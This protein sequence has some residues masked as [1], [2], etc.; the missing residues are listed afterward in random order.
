MTSR[1]CRRLR[2]SNRALVMELVEELARRGATFV[3]PVNAGKLRLA[4]SVFVTSAGGKLW[5]GKAP[6]SWEKPLSQSRP[7]RGLREM[8]ECP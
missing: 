8:V 3:V 2:S 1:W 5:R 4:D 7:G 6:A